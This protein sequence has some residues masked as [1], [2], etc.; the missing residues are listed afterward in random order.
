MSHVMCHV[1]HV[2]CHMSRVTCHVSHVKCH[3]S[4]VT[5]HFFFS[6][7]FWQS[8][9]A[10][11]WRVCYQRGQPRLVL[12]VNWNWY[13][14][15]GFWM[16]SFTESTKNKNIQRQDI[17]RIYLLN[18]T[19][20]HLYRWGKRRWSNSTNINRGRIRG[21]STNMSRSRSLRRSYPLPLLLKHWDK[22][23]PW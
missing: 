22:G 8:G 5:C 3:M 16:C 1:S 9:E 2:T 6:F 18:Q 12:L 11:R 17:D 4:R 7:L 19:I 23:S 20:V 14:C 13:V 10:Y 15:P 21:S